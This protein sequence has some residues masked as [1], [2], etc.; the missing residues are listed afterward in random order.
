MSCPNCGTEVPSGERSCKECGLEVVPLAETVVEPAPTLN[1]PQSQMNI[2]GQTEVGKDRSQ[3]SPMNLIAGIVVFVIGLL[4]LIG[5]L[6][7]QFPNGKGPGILVMVCGA[8]ICGL[9]F[10]PKPAID[11]Q[12]P[13]P[14]ST[15]ERL[16]RIFYEPAE[17]FRNLRYHP[18]WLAAFL[19]VALSGAAYQVALR[20]RLGPERIA[21]DY[22]SRVIEGG[23]LQNSPTPV[24]PEVA[25]QYMIKQAIL[26]DTSDK[27]SA[28][29]S[30]VAGA[31][32][33]MLIL[34]GL[35]TLGVL[36]FGGRMD[37][38]R[39]LSISVYSS[40]P[41]AAILFVLN[42]ILLFIKSPD[43]I[44][45]LKAQ[46]HGLARAD[47]GLLFSAAEQHPPLL[48]HPYLYAIAST[49]GIFSLY[50]W[51]LAVNGLKNTGEK[52]KGGSAWTIVF[53]VWLLGI[54]VTLVLVMLAPA[55]AAA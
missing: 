31:F 21:D 44:V 15:G 42:L 7:F 34:A 46:S 13:V 23:Y 14:L 20:Q 32:I 47:L 1:L 41:P 37:F 9:S 52:I 3:H 36:A 28:F 50:G 25:R 39:G 6:K 22:A 12:A 27:V 49:I 29:I 26:T 30:G 16:T 35:Y 19:V 55:F 24:S 40:L 48:D 2:V 10:V 4:L 5:N 8:L 53:L 43:D 18:R 54:I 33:F 45:P 11:P 38:W 51:W 17:V